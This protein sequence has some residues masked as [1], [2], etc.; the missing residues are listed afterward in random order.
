MKYHIQVVPKTH[1]VWVNG[2]KVKVISHRHRIVGR[3]PNGN[4]IKVDHLSQDDKYNRQTH[5]ELRMYR[6]LRPYDRRNFPKVVK[7]GTY[8][9]GKETR[10]WMIQKDMNLDNHPLVKPKHFE[11]VN[12]LAS[13]YQIGDIETRQHSR[14]AF[15]SDHMNWTLTENGVPMIFDF[16][17][18]WG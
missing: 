9:D 11:R 10:F 1:K 2:D 18:R 17:L 12:V 13:R 5:R 4:I 14:G 7:W 8:V 6:E 15:V 3:L 16:G